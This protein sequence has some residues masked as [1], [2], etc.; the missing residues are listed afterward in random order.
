MSEYTR[1]TELLVDAR[2]GDQ[3]EMGRLA[4]VV[5]ERIYPFVLRTTMDR[6]ATEDII[7]ET[8]LTMLARLH[9]LR[10]VKRFWP[11]V[12]RIAWS[13]IQDRLRH[14]R[15]QSTYTTAA[16]REAASERNDNDSVLDAQVREETLRQISLAVEQLNARQRDILRMRYYEQLPYTEIASRTSTTPAR[17]RVHFHRAKRSLKKELACCL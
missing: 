13:R 6:D 8:L 3:A 9:T 5:W 12:Y 11:W 14:R 15:L 1:T 10:N 2:R 4:V 7:Q 17:A 16:L